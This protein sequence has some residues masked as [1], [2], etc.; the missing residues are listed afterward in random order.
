LNQQNL[1][2]I[3]I[4]FAAAIGGF[5]LGFDG[6][7]ISG[8]VPFYKTVFG[9]KDGSFMLG[10]SVS[11]IIWGAIVGNLIAGPLSDLIGRKK[12]L[13]IAALLF[14]TTGLICAFANNITVFIIGRIIGGLGVGIAILVAPVYIAEISPAGKRGWLVSFNQLLIVIGLTTAYFS[15]YFILRTVTDPLIN[16]RWMLGIETVPAIIYF[17]WV[18]FIPESPRW[19]VMH[20]MENRAFVILSR[21]HTKGSAAAEFDDIKQSVETTEKINVTGQWEKL[22]SIR[23]KKVLIIGLGL[24]ILQ[25]FSGINAILYYTP[26]VFESAGGG[27]NAAF[28]QAIVLGVV[29]VVMTIV[30]MFLIDRIGRKPLL[31]IGV[32]IMALSLTSTGILFKNAHYFFSRDQIAGAAEQ[33]FME[34]RASNRWNSNDSIQAA[35]QKMVFIEKVLPLAG[36][37]FRSETFFYSALTNALAGT[38]IR[39][40]GYKSVLLKNSI[41]INSN[42][43]LISILGFIAGF[44]I[45]LGPVMWA[46]LS[47]IFPNHLRGLAISVVGS[48]NAMASFIV[49]TFF[50]VQLEKFGSSGTYFI[51]AGC[52]YFCLWFVWKY[53]VET[54]GKTLEKLEK[55][56]V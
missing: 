8:A 13:L 24:G 25:Q 18:L 29:F 2:I 45:S 16:W 56:I 1:Y 19:L 40:E 54:K 52:M 42:L 3:S 5:L 23:M 33:V 28:L 11:C 4:A 10:F 36:K 26:M 41:R 17:I 49:A 53:V 7:V 47:E 32:S 38:D 51:Y 9:L 30:S 46:I 34:E 22:F 31:Y 15:N 14:T 6:S 48:V 12:S 39:P 35:A 43:V 55:E 37:S 27:R 20:G 44:S 50:P 21:L